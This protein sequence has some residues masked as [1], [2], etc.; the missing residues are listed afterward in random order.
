MNDLHLN[1]LS[2][3]FKSTNN[4]SEDIITLERHPLK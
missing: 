4:R 3:L 2:K 1:M